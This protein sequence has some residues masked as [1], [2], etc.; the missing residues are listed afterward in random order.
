MTDRPSVRMSLL[1]LPTNWRVF[2]SPGSFYKSGG[3]LFINPNSQINVKPDRNCVVQVTRLEQGF[4]VNM[5][6]LPRN[7]RYMEVTEKVT[8][9]NNFIPLAEEGLF[10]IVDSL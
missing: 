10:K 4:L 8:V 6:T 9:G 7:L 2:V 3:R 5:S 1:E